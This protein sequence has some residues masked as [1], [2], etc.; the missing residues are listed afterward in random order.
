MRHIE[1]S[2]WIELELAVSLRR[3]GMF[4]SRSFSAELRESPTSELSYSIEMDA[5]DWLGSPGAFRMDLGIPKIVGPF[6][7]FVA[8]W[9]REIDSTQDPHS[10]GRVNYVFDNLHG[11][12]SV[13]GLFFC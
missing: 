2:T 4:M 3:F 1:A 9:L 13:I 6:L 8:I 11:C 5:P 10:A 7:A 12:I